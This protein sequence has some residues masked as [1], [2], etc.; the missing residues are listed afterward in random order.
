MKP[1]RAEYDAVQRQKSLL[2]GITGDDWWTD[3]GGRVYLEAQGDEKPPAHIWLEAI[4][5]DAAEWVDNISI[6]WQ[7]VLPLTGDDSMPALDV[8]ADMRA[9]LTSECAMGGDTEAGSTIQFRQQGGNY[10]AVSITI[11][12]QAAV[13]GRA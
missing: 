13:N 12:S 5:T 2:E 1:A 9:A 11:S 6:T 10:A 4:A 3:I 7:A 8:L